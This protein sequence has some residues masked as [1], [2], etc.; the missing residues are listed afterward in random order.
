V[1]GRAADRLR[2]R[3]ETD[4]FRFGEA[5]GRAPGV[6]KSRRNDNLSRMETG[7]ERRESANVVA[8]L[9]E[10]NAVE[11][12]GTSRDEA[13][14]DFLSG[15]GWYRGADVDRL[16]EE[17][18]GI[19]A[20]RLVRRVEGKTSLA[21]DKAQELRDALEQSLSKCFT[22]GKQQ[23]GEL[24]DIASKYLNREQLKIL[25]EAV[26]AGVRPLPNES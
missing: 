20:A 12:Q 25:K 10:D 6:V 26:Q 17:E 13:V 14:R 18:A 16:S 23:T 22:S 8:D 21:K 19:I 2:Q 15:K 24:E 7:L 11:V 3:F 4:S 5:A 9:K 1:S